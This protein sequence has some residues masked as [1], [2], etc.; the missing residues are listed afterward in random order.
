M[1]DKALSLK[2]LQLIFG[3]LNLLSNIALIIL[4]INLMT[5]TERTREHEN[6]YSYG[7]SEWKHSMSYRLRVVTALIATTVALTSIQGLLGWISLCTNKTS[8][9]YVY[10]LLL[11][12]NLVFFIATIAFDGP[13]E[14]PIIGI[15]SDLLLSSIMFNFIKKLKDAIY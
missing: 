13:W 9:L 10:S 11:F 2:F 7:S 3:A 8:Y 12:L 14:G 5:V 1:S 15:I 6:P 4:I